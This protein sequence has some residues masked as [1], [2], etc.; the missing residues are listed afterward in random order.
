MAEFRGHGNRPHF[1]FAKIAEE[2]VDLPPKP[3][4]VRLQNTTERLWLR[5]G[6]LRRSVF[7]LFAPLLQNINFKPVHALRNF[8]ITEF[9]VAWTGR[10]Q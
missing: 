10:F 5:A 9:P 2:L 8:L 6:V 1:V 7:C 4:I 3:S